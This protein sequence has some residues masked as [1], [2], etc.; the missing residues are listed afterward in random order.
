MPI[1]SFG[2]LGLREMVMT[3]GASYL[4]IDTEVSVAMSLLT[5]LA[6]LLVSLAGMYFHFRPD[7]VFSPPK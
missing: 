3:F 4:L 1:P 5:Y 2:G 7:N 6:I